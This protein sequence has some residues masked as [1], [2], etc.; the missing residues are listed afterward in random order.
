MTD[1]AIRKIVIVGGGT[2]GWM[3]AAPLAL[4]LGKSREIV[5]VESPEIGTVGVGEA[6]LPTIR[7]FNLA[8]GLD[9]ADFVRKTQATF[10]LGIEFKDWGHVG[11]RF[12]HGFGDFGPPIE[13]RSPYQY[14]L[15]LSR[16]FK[17]MPSYEEWSMATAMARKHRFAP[18]HGDQPAAS[19]AYS[20][21]FHFDAGLYAAYLRDYAMRRGVA[22]I[23][24]MITGVEQHP[25]SGFITAVKLRDGRRVEGDLFID[26][27]GFRGLLIEGVY[28]AGYDDWSAMLPCNSALAVP[29]EK[30]GEPAPY[31]LSTARSAGWTWRIPLQHRTGNGHVYCDGFTTD[32]AAS[33]VLLAG[34]DGRALDEPRK[35][36]FTTGRRRKSWIKNCVAIGLSSGFLEPLESTSI[37]IIE[38]AVGWL[39]DYFP[40]R[41]CRP[42]LADEFNRLVAQRF[43]FVRD[44]IILHYK[45]TR[46]D[47]SEFWRYCAD[48][49]I[50]D[51]LRHQIELFRETGRVVIHDPEG[52]S[53]ASHVSI[54]AGLG[55]VPK[56]DDPLIDLMDQR[57][58]HAHFHKV[59]ESI[60]R[61]VDAMPGHGQYLAHLT[62]APPAEG[63]AA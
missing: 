34:L 30:A 40:D 56:A 63:L 11:N 57:K 48:M 21:A 6:T 41:Y 19:N 27:S 42:E 54:L 50:P 43:E 52:F 15:R 14:W 47:D 12:F 62:G 45:V 31:T 61:T 33:R 44:F 26:C 8:L 36:R 4:K 38:N 5:L 51:T 46:R 39:L 9:G 22:R 24:G 18:P 28:Q 58:L 55:V 35:L 16:E 59:R 53:V 49:P 20:Y 17:D 25:D 23:E 60:A 3:T 29:C 10:K 1:S 2:A 7:Y 13:H 37:N 32:E